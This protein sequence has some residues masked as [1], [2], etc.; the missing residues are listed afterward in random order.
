MPATRIAPNRRHGAWSHRVHARPRSARVPEG[1]AGP[2]A[3]RAGAGALLLLAAGLGL[4][5]VLAWRLASRAGQ[6]SVVTLEPLD[7]V[8]A[9]PGALAEHSLLLVT[10][11]TTRA[12]RLGC[13]GNGAIRTPTFDRLAA[14]GILFA[15]TLAVAPTTL[16][17]HASIMTGLY[18]TEHG[19]RA[20]GLFRLEAEAETLAERLR[21]A[22]FATGAVV[23]SFVLDRQFGFAQG[24]D[25]YDDELFSANVPTD[26][27]FREREAAETTR[28]ALRFLDQVGDERFFLWVHYFDP[29][30]EYAP[31]A[32]F[33][34]AYEANLYD[35]EIAY[36][37]AALARL[38]EKIDSDRTLVAVVGDH[39][40][41]LGQ[42]DEFTHS[43]L[44]Y[45]S[46][47]HVPLLLNADGLA[48]GVLCTRPMSQVDVLPVCL[49]L[50]GITSG[51]AAERAL[52]AVPRAH[53]RWFE[54]LAGTLEYG[55]EPLYGVVVGDDKYIHGADPELYDRASDPGELANLAGRRGARVEELRQLVTTTFADDLRTTP[56]PTVALEG[57]ELERL[58]NLGYFGAGTNGASAD[59][60][61]G[62]PPAPRTMMSF[63]KRVEFAR[64][65]DKPFAEQIAELEAVLAERP[66]FY[67]A[68]SA[69]GGVYRDIPDLE[70]AA[71]ALERCLVLRPGLPGSATDLAL[72]RTTQGQ[73]DEARR[74]LEPIVEAYPT[75]TRSR[76][77][78]GTVLARLGRF[79]EACT[80]LVAVFELDPDYPNVAANL[81]QA[82]LR[83]GRA[84]EVV[85]LFEAHLAAE[86]AA[87]TIR[88]LL[89]EL[90]A[91]R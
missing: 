36:V 82:A 14:T 53:P 60:R 72:V 21:A 87:A 46:T 22:G 9:A 44:T 81:A 13:Y 45:D 48:G 29:H 26:R 11:D 89:G 55:W 37:D 84:D 42:H 83:A 7:H 5:G 51:P 70:A 71:Q 56:G 63:L 75:L 52:A 74:L 2:N 61:G 19:V 27:H 73:N 68:W 3:G 57:D 38:L 43:Y 12:D 16:P 24:F 66:D 20:N 28:R 54:T 78:Y 10:L 62:P 34:A 18:P 64:T 31:P 8:P 69:L 77:L 79:D 30:H 65:P 41:G 85:A 39:G 76:A 67:P 23:S 90:E 25:V 32:P 17:S 6:P 49:A 58:Q 33:D 15:D 1:T 88:R 50:L 4:A 47:L 80:Q 91:G 86:P 35:G 40:E 59:A